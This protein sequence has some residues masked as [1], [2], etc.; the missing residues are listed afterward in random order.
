[1][2]MIREEARAAILRW[3]EVVAAGLLALT[4]LWL[5]WLGGYL[6]VP[7]GLLCLALAALWARQAWRRMRFAQGVDA[8]GLIEVDEAQI[9]YMGPT[10]GGFVAL[11]DLTEVRVLT[12]HGK[13]LWRL[14]Q[15]DGQALLIPV[16]ATGSERLFDAFTV[17]PGLDTQALVDALAPGS[18]DRV[19]WRRDAGRPRPRLPGN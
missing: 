15:A 10:F 14:K 18:G 17:L 2:A 19:V 13:R 16:D 5:I 8:P 9:A 3:R 11:P 7:M 4:G 1:M 12:I 6:L